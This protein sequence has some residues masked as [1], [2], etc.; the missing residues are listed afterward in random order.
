[1]IRE[2]NYLQRIVDA[3]EQTVNRARYVLPNLVIGQN[4]AA[5]DQ[6]WA[7]WH[8]PVDDNSHIEFELSP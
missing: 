8:V 6:N 7:R 2:E 1:L 5:G 3:H 4:A